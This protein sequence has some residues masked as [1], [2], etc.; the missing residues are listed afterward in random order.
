MTANSAVKESLNMPGPEQFERSATPFED[1]SEYNRIVAAQAASRTVST[2]SDIKYILQVTAASAL[3]FE[4]TDALD[5]EDDVDTGK[6]KAKADYKFIQSKLPTTQDVVAALQRLCTEYIVAFSNGVITEL[7]FTAA[8][9]EEVKAS[10]NQ[11]LMNVGKTP[12]Y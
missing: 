1:G 4:I 9:L 3:K 11:L 2:F 7:K 8:E 6:I 5:M 10:T 12:I